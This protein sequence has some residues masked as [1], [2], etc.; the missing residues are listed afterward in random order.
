M[1]TGIFGGSFNP[2]HLA[3][4]IIAETMR[5]VHALDRVLWIP[6]AHPPHKDPAALAPAEHRL[7]MVQLATAD[8]PHFEVSTIE[9]E[10]PGPGYTIDTIL[11][12]KQRSS[13]EFLLIVGGDS[14]AD[15]HTWRDPLHIL[16]EVPL[17][18]YDRPGAAASSLPIPK[19]RLARTPVPLLSISSTDIR[20]RCAAGTS[21]RYL[22]PGAVE[23]YIREHQLYLS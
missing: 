18:V 16:A 13:D 6:G 1:R 2:P 8:H 19:E 10:R 7:A 3:H 5:D 15:F 12:L 17:L 14:L 20:R 23:A 11:E 22:V 21:I 4:L 9:L